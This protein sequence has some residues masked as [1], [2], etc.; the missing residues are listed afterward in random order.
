LGVTVVLE[1]LTTATREELLLLFDVSLPP[2][3]QADNVSVV[4]SKPETKPFL[5]LNIDTSTAKKK[6][7]KLINQNIS[8]LFKQ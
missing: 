7:W 4:T 1:E 2:P 3:P 5:L 6:I 8:N